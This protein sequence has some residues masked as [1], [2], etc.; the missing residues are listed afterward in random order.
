MGKMDIANTLILDW[1]DLFY[2]TTNAVRKNVENLPRL[3]YL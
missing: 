3:K 1:T 2:P